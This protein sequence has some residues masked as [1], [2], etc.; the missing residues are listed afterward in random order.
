MT[1][2]PRPAF[3]EAALRC[4]PENLW[5]QVGARSIHI[6]VAGR[7]LAERL[8]D[9]MRHI[10]FA[11]PTAAADLT[12][13]AWSV[14]ETGVPLPSG[15]NW[16]KGEPLEW[17]APREGLAISCLPSAEELTRISIARPF[18]WSLVSLLGERG[19]PAM[20][21]ALICAPGGPGLLLLGPNGS[22]KS[23]TCLRAIQAG[24]QLVG[25]DCLVVE[26][27]PEGFLGH[28]LYCSCNVTRHTRD[29]LPRLPGTLHLPFG[30]LPD[31]KAILLLPPSGP[32]SPMRRSMPIE[33]L[34]FP[35]IVGESA[36]SRIVPI[37][38][39]EAHRRFMPSLRQALKLP[40]NLRRA[41][42]DAVLPL[43]SLPA[44]RVELGTDIGRVPA[45]LEE[46][47][48]MLA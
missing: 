30:A 29:L 6:R 13:C 4:S 31:A 9:P 11:A 34:V 17:V 1:A 35:V 45:C 27:T 19:L 28:S 5:V 15:T 46:L 25:E 3:E 40:E 20:H 12:V 23:T 22:G 48:G 41:H 7:K 42:L 44:F 18:Q 24:F 14:A 32:E 47:S 8:F 33:A 39:G 43:T 10:A 21:G 38:K 26:R 36:G 16:T 2:T 37:S